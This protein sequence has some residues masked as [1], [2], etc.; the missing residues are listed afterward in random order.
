[1]VLEP[2]AGTFSVDQPDSFYK[3]KKIMLLRPLAIRKKSSR[4]LISGKTGITFFERHR[5]SKRPKN[6]ILNPTL[7]FS[8]YKNHCQPQRSYYT[9]NIFR[10]HTC[11]LSKFPN[12]SLN[13]K[14]KQKNFRGKITLARQKRIKGN[15][16]KLY[17]RAWYR[18]LRPV[19]GIPH[20][21]RHSMFLTYFFVSNKIFN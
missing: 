17:G 9:L 18:I 10:R 6:R 2:E 14:K 21:Y 20:N 7:M 3:I 11:H 8:S 16:S 15:C 13:W 1:M 19:A 5:S 12:I 4:N